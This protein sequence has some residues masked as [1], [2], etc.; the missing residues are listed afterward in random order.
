ML[1]P[2]SIGLFVQ[3]PGANPYAVGQIYPFSADKFLSDAFGLSCIYDADM[4]TLSIAV[5]PRTL[6]LTT[7]TLGTVGLYRVLDARQDWLI[8]EIQFDSRMR[9]SDNSWLVKFNNVGGNQDLII[10]AQ[11]VTPVKSYYGI[12]SVE[13]SEKLA[14]VAA[15]VY[16]PYAQAGISDKDPLQTAPACEIAIHEHEDLDVLEL[17]FSKAEPLVSG[18]GVLTYAG[19]GNRYL[20]TAKG[21]V[22]QTVDKA[23]WTLGASTFIEPRAGNIFPAYALHATVWETAG[24]NSVTA[25]EGYYN[26]SGFQERMVGWDIAGATG[27]NSEFRVDFNKVPW[28]GDT[29]TVSAFVSAAEGHK[30]WIG[31]SRYKQTGEFIATEWSQVTASGIAVASA[32]WVRSRLAPPQLGY[33]ALSLRVQDLNPGDV[34]R[35]IAAFP[36]VEYSGCPGTRSSG[37]RF[38]DN[39]TFEPDYD[40]DTTY[41]RFDVGVTPNYDGLPGGAGPQL[42]F[43]TRDAT[44]LNGFWCGHRPDGLLEFGS[45]DATGQTFVRSVSAIQLETSQVYKITCYWDSTVKSMRID[46]NNA[47]SVDTTL[48][49]VTVPTTITKIR[50]GTRFQGDPAGSFQLHSFAHTQ[51]QD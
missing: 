38:A 12:A 48:P 29:V 15:R 19:G 25:V 47:I 18:T 30:T 7:V 51:T 40:V 36:V 44:G 42:F 13:T 20:P 2:P 22:L 11:L 41:G 31:V 45:A 4:D 3:Q 43:D 26:L 24:T 21:P 6:D 8:R 32:S 1:L 34:T 50:F 27:L 39:L 9:R 14:P 23:P 33:V 37:I 49:T 35:L 28:S 17:D 16:K 5:G 46:V 10:G